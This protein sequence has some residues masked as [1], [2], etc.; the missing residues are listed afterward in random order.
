[1]KAGFIYPTVPPLKV[2]IEGT[3]VPFRAG[4][5]ASIMCRS[6]GSKPPATLDL[7][8]DGSTGFKALPPQ[9]SLDQNTT[10]RRGHL[11]PSSEDNGRTVTCTANNPLVPDYR[12]S[13][14]RRLQVHCEYIPVYL[15]LTQPAHLSTIP[16]LGHLTCCT[17]INTS[18]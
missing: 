4:V 7:K 11:L 10:I 18:A 16:C 15:H 6:T 8:I 13:A 1:M 14:T 3:D 5:Q 17:S 12:L 2:E 9:S